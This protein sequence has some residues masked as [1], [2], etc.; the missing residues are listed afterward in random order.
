MTSRQVKSIIKTG[1][2]TQE[3]INAMVNDLRESMDLPKRDDIDFYPNYAI[4]AEKNP[5]SKK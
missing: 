4:G 5:T 3:E 1:V 2:L